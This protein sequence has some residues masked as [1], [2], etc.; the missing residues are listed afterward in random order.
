M[1]LYGFTGFVIGFVLGLIANAQLLKGIPKE[2][3]IKDKSLR[4]RYGLLNWG[5]ALLGMAIGMAI[6]QAKN[7]V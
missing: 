3:Y 1:G 6:W 4:T 7:P 5:I 2:R